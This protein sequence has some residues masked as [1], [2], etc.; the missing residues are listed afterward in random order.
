MVMTVTDL[1]D[2]FVPCLTYLSGAVRAF[3][4]SPFACTWRSDDV[5][6]AACMGPF[7]VQ[8]PACL[9]WRPGVE[10]WEDVK[11]AT[12]L[13]PSAFPCLILTCM[14]CMR[15]VTSMGQWTEPLPYMFRSQY[16]DGDK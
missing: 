11:A 13:R 4:P 5:R 16:K 1:S 3:M 10:H 9:T 2:A 7:C 15:W 8:A 12:L 6:A 14:C